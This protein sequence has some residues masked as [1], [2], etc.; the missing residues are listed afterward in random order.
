M[1][2]YCEIYLNFKWKNNLLAETKETEN[3]GWLQRLCVICP[4][5]QIVHWKEKLRDW[6]KR[7][8]LYLPH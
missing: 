2:Y 7:Q 1:F 8:M 3:L 6:D 4:S 5:A